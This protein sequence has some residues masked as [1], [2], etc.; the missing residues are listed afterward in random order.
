[1]KFLMICILVLTLL[2]GCSSTEDFKRLA[3]G[4]SQTDVADIFGSPLAEYRDDPYIYYQYKLSSNPYLQPNGGKR[5]YYFVFKE[6]KLIG[7]YNQLDFT[8]MVDGHNFNTSY[9]FI[10]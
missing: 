6:K 5:P 1:M 3:V 8:V 2:T 7:I 9:S 10:Y 4:A